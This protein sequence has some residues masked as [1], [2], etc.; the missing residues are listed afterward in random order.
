MKEVK[1]KPPVSKKE[2][3]GNSDC[4]LNS[5]GKQIVDLVADYV[6]AV[7][8]EDEVS[9]IQPDTMY[10][11]PIVEVNLDIINSITVTFDRQA[12][13]CYDALVAHM[14]SGLDDG[15]S[16]MFFDLT[17]I[18]RGTRTVRA[19]SIII[20][21]TVAGYYLPDLN[22]WF[23]GN[24]T[25]HQHYIT[26]IMSYLFPQIIRQLP[27]KSCENSITA[28]YSKKSTG[29]RLTVS[30]GADPEF[31][32]IKN[33]R[34]V[35]ADTAL[36]INNH[37][38]ADI[39]LDGAMSQLEFRPKP[40]TPQQVV[41]NIRHLVKKFSQKYPEFDLTDAGHRYPLGGHI[42]VGV[43][44]QID[45]PRELI[46]LL[47]DFI[48][49]PTIELSGGA[50]SSYK[51][52]GAA[53]SQ[54]HGIEYRSTPTA[55]FQNPRMTHVTLT[56]MKNLCEHFFN[57]D[58]VKYND[59]P[60][61]DDYMQVGGLSKNQA[62]YFLKFCREY[63]P[64]NSI[65]ASWKVAPAPIVNSV[66]T[67]SPQ[68]EFRDEWDDGVE[69]IIRDSLLEA[70]QTTMPMNISLY[71]LH[72]DRGENMCTIALDGTSQCSSPLPRPTIRDNTLSIGFSADIRRHG[73]G[74]SRRR[75][76]VREV[77]RM[78]AERERTS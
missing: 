46:S 7:R 53:R 14:N 48:G 15:F 34:V 36:Q 22:S 38:S 66:P 62:N 78:V 49:K 29:K 40:G 21:D 24:W 45:I 59:T 37:T 33:G 2:V 26:I 13:N 61:I 20:N 63:K 1:G 27:M 18:K 68:I 47:D 28:G 70:I 10:I 3:I 32:V 12:P 52:L 8:V 44:Q 75:L 73:L 74:S 58:I 5:C 19:V 57:G 76:L 30:L 23:L 9:S 39:G 35:K 69:S 6:H 67:Q 77:A 51:T 41:K 60:T 43:G 17:G 56:L 11:A 25:W 31:E 71:G 54:P 65:R 42:H 16:N 50:R 64:Q 4:R 55:V 72:R